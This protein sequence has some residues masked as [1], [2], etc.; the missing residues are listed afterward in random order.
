MN[1]PEDFVFSQSSLQDFVDCARRFEL[2]YIKRLR[3]PAVQAAPMLEFERKMQQGALFH[4]LVRQ[5]MLGISA[6]L[7]AR[8]IGDD[9]DMLNWWQ[10]YINSDFVA[11]LPEKRRPEITLST[12]LGNYRL[13]AK[14][15]LLAIE[16]DGQ[17][18]IVDWKTGQHMPKATNLQHRLQTIVYRYV[19]AKAGEDF[20][21]GQAV[22]PANIKMI[23]WYAAHHGQT[24]AFDYSAEQL[25]KDETYLEQLVE[26]IDAMQS[27]PLTENTRH[28]AFCVYRSLCDR[29]R[30]AGDVDDLFEDEQSLETPDEEFQIDLDQIAEVEF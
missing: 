23:Y 5:H 6:E 27:F 2:R 18:R 16:P 20:N 25:K 3:W 17:A 30:E 7:L 24:I 26:D 9:E 13:M 10:A 19:L 12:P 22:K 1:L 21:R 14:Y 29:G 28:C 15:D 4:K 11:K 8:Q